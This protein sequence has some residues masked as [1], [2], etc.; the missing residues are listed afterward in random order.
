MDPGLTVHTCNSSYWGVE[1]GGLQVQDYK[2]KVNKT[3]SQ[4]QNTNNKWHSTCLSCM[5][6]YVQSSVPQRKSAV[7]EIS[8]SC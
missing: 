3:L 8:K 4:K 5:R 7:L 6:T 2:V 1:V